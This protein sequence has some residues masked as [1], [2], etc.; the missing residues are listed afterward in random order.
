MA[1]SSLFG[2]DPRFQDGR[3]HYWHEATETERRAF[4]YYDAYEFSKRIGDVKGREKNWE[5]YLHYRT[6]ALGGEL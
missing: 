2:P 3:N 6:R 5:Y 1:W 4:F